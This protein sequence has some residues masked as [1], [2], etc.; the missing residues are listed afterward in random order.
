MGLAGQALDTAPT[1]SAPRL[2]VESLNQMIDLQTDRV[3]GNNNRV[4]GAV[5]MLE[6]AGAAV[7]MGLLVDPL[8]Q[9]AAGQPRPAIPNLIP[10]G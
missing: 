6:V 4:P 8:P 10:I 7:A 9:R 3:S 5:M 1:A 2:Y